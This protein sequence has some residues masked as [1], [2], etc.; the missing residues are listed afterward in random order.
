MRIGIFGGTFDP[1]HDGHVNPVARAAERFGLE[2]VLWIPARISP[3][4]AEF[5][6]VIGSADHRLIMF[7][8][9]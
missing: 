1:V 7:D 6:H 2:R 3:A 4:G 5:D 9:K 8:H